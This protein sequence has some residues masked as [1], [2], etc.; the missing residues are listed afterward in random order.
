MTDSRTG[1]QYE[2]PISARVPG[3]ERAGFDHALERAAGLCPVS[4][5]LRGNVEVS[6]HGELKA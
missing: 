3:L 6:L 4:S 2:F 5:A 1:K